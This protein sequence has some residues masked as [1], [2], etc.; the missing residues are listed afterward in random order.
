V[1]HRRPPKT[2]VR[3]IGSSPTYGDQEGSAYNGHFGCACY[4]PLFVFNQLSDVAMS[5]GVFAIRQRAQRRWLAGGAG[6]SDR[7]LPGHRQA[8]LFSRRRGFR[9]SRNLRNPGNRGDRLHDPAAGK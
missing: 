4:H 9:Q 7:P 3:D 6:T 5:S 8:P 2:I 1:H